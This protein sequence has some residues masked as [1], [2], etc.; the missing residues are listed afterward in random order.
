MEI[1]WKSDTGII[2][3]FDET[4]EFEKWFSSECWTLKNGSWTCTSCAGGQPKLNEFKIKKL[5]E[6]GD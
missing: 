2:V 3:G 6:K 5:L 1:L 4:D